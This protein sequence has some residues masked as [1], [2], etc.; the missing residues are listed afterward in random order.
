MAGNPLRQTEGFYRKNPFILICENH[1]K[2]TTSAPQK[3]HRHSPV[4]ERADDQGKAR[5]AGFRSI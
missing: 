4:M 1:D 2:D 3:T 5:K